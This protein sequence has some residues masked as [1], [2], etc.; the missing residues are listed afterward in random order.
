MDAPAV[1]GAGFAAGAKFWLGVAD[2]RAVG[3]T[4]LSTLA[5]VVAVAAPAIL[6]VQP[7]LL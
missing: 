4:R 1:F 7:L 3:A 2:I 6:T 5:A